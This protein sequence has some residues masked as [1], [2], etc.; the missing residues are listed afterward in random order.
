M[1]QNDDLI[2]STDDVTDS[3]IEV[4]DCVLAKV[5]GIVSDVLNVPRNAI[6]LETRAADVDAW[7]SFGHVRIILA[8]DAAFGVK[9]SMEAIEKADGIGG[10]VEAVEGARGSH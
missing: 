1:G 2:G 4:G 5:K 9:L 6:R 3:D 8:I 10:L 7:D